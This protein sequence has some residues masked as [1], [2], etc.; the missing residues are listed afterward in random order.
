MIANVISLLIGICASGIYDVIKHLYHRCKN[1]SDVCEPYSKE[2]ISCVKIEFYTGFFLGI[3]LTLI[4]DTRYNV[5]NTL[6]DVISYFSFFIA[7]MGFMCLVD[8]AKY[9][10][11]YHTKD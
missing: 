3:I 11:N 10:L 1:S 7:L 4:P 8:V 2:Y 5:V 6:I 9:F